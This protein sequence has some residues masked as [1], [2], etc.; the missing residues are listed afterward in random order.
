[1]FSDSASIHA[2]HLTSRAPPTAGV[3]PWPPDDD[4]IPSGTVLMPSSC[5]QACYYCGQQASFSVNN[6]HQVLR[7]LFSQ[8]R[9]CA[10]SL[11]RIFWVTYTSG[12]APCDFPPI[13][14]R[15]WDSG[16]IFCC[17]LTEAGQGPGYQGR[18]QPGTRAGSNPSG[19]PGSRQ[20]SPA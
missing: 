17:H 12:F 15:N 7:Y 9:K 20:V 1:M 5:E 2:V 18:R 19:F 11:F 3:A 13:S 8:L 6:H 14:K 4:L 10:Y 16:E